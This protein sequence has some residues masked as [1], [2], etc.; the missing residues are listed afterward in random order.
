[1]DL[2]FIDIYPYYLSPPL[3]LVAG[4]IGIQQ[5]SSWMNQ[6]YFGLDKELCPN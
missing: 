6:T 1:M 4:S 2:F 5:K 3:E